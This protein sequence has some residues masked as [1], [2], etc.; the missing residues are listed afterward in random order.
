MLN[1]VT[2]RLVLVYVMPIEAKQ[3]ATQDTIAA[4]EAGA[5]RHNV[6]RCFPLTEVAAAHE[7]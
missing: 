3:K 2:I 7:A 5:L 4:L 6:A 1:G